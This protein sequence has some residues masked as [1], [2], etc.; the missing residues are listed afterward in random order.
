ME[1]FNPERDDR[2]SLKALLAALDASE[3]ALQR[4]PPIRGQDNVGDWA[5]RGR[6]GHVYPDGTGYLL[7][8]SPVEE[9]APMTRTGAR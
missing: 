3:R 1:H 6:H 8:V 2:A 7:Y 4:D 9:V 5:I